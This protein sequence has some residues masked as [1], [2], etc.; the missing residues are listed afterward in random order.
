MEVLNS[1]Y[2]ANQR[3]CMSCLSVVK[4]Y[5][6][7]SQHLLWDFVYP[8]PQSW[9]SDNLRRTFT[10]LFS[11]VWW[12]RAT[13]VGIAV[14]NPINLDFCFWG[15][16]L[17]HRLALANMD[18]A[19][20]KNWILSYATPIVSRTLD[21]NHGWEWYERVCILRYISH[22]GGRIIPISAIEQWLN[23]RSMTTNVP[24]DSKWQSV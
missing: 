2:L 3:T 1:Y 18:H 19:I 4:F 17:L 12:N 15:A 8:L 14:E 6:S 13:T 9:P 21:A 23:F 20:L 11:F 22:S 7:T 24:S 10:S 5:T 16:S